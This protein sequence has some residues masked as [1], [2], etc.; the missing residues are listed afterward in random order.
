MKKKIVAFCIAVAL[1]ISAFGGMAA[2]A[3]V[4]LEECDKCFQTTV[5][6]F[7]ENDDVEGNKINAVRRPVYDINLQNLG[8]V[9]EFEI[10]GGSGYAIIICDNGNYIAQEFVPDGENPYAFVAEEEL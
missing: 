9:Y 6:G 10:I 5:N 8:Y 3:E 2:F 1:I 7:L 4:S